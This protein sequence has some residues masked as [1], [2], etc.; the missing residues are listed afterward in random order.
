MADPTLAEIMTALAD[1]IRS[2]VNGLDASLQVNDRQNPN[3]T[4]PALDI[5]PADPFQDRAAFGPGAHAV[6]FTVRARVATA[7]NTGGQEL[8]LDLMDPRAG[9]SVAQAIEADTTLS[10]KVEDTAVVE[11]PS[12]FLQFNDI[13]G[14]GS[15]LGCQ[16]RVAVMI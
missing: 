16:W 9:T 8:L 1:Q 4:P 10:G 6:Y 5:Y 12:G 2:G 13:A 3:P 14:Q 11:G 7:E 15:W